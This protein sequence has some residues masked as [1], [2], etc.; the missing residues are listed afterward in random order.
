MSVDPMKKLPSLWCS[1]LWCPFL[2]FGTF[3]ASPSPDEVSLPWEI[4]GFILENEGKNH[5]V[6]QPPE[7]ETTFFILPSLS[8]STQQM[9]VEVQFLLCKSVSFSCG[10]TKA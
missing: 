5:F 6:Y 2:K 8:H 7:E 3:L 9:G 10:Q 1:F 4:F